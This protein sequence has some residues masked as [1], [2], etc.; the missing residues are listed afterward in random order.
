MLSA[1]APDW[2]EILFAGPP[3]SVLI[4]TRVSIDPNSVLLLL[5]PDNTVWP[6]LDYLLMDHKHC[7]GGVWVWLAP[8]DTVGAWGETWTL[9]LLV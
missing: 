1:L 9:D 6:L 7:Q 4:N 2:L 3:K 8:S 5:Q